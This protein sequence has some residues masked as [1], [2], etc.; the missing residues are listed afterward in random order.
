MGAGDGVPGRQQGLGKPGINM[1]N[2]QWGN[3]D[4]L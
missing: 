2:L 3:A 1:G 4:R